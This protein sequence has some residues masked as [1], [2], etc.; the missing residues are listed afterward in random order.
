[1]SEPTDH[2][3][4]PG[5]VLIERVW[6][7]IDES[8][9]TNLE[10]DVL[11][12][13]DKRCKTQINAGDY[14]ATVSLQELYQEKF[15]PEYVP[16]ANPDSLLENAIPFGVVLD[17]AP[18]GDPEQGWE[19]IGRLVFERI[20]EY[21]EDANAIL[22][23]YDRQRIR[24]RVAEV[25]RYFALMRQ[26]INGDVPYEF[27]PSLV[28]MVKMDVLDRESPKWGDE[29]QPIKWYL[30]QTLE[31]IEDAEP[32]AEFATET[33]D[34][35]EWIVA[36]E[37]ALETLRSFTQSAERDQVAAYQGRAIRRIFT[38]AVTAG[39][40][41]SHAHVVTAST[42]GGKTEAFFFPLLAYAIAAHEAGIDGTRAI[43]GY[44][45]VDLCDNQFERF[46]DYIHQLNDLLGYE[47]PTF[48]EAPITIGLQHGSRDKATVECPY[49]GCDGELEAAKDDDSEVDYFTPDYFQCTD[50]ESHEI[51]YATARRDK[52]AD[53]FITT[54][55]S[56]HRRLMDEHGRQAF[57]SREYPPKFIGLDEVHV[58]SS[59]YGMHVA[60]VMRRL[61]Q[62]VRGTENT[63]EIVPF[64]ASATI[65]DADDFT[66]RIFGVDDATETT[67][68]E[69][70]LKE[71]GREYVIFVKSPDPRTVEIPTGDSVFKPKSEWGEKTETTTSNLS[72]MIQIAFGFYHTIYKD[73][74]G[75]IPKDK[76]L[77]FV[78][79]IDSVGRLAEYLHDAET[80]EKGLFELRSPDAFLPGQSE[81][82]PDCPKSTFRSGAEDHERAV[83]EPLPPNQHL[84]ECP[85]YE[86]GECWWTM[87]DDTLMPMDVG[88]HKSGRSQTP[89]GDDLDRW[90][91]L[92]S[93]SA[94][95]VGFDHP[96]IIGTF[97]YRA[98]MS[99]PGYVQ[100]RG[101][102]G[103]G[104]SDTPISVVVLGSSSEDSFY[105]HNEQQLSRPQ[106]KHLRI[107][108]DETNRFVR[109]E[110]MISA[111]FDY[112]NLRLDGNKADEI[113]KNLN[114]ET[115]RAEIRSHDD[116]IHDWL[117]D[118]FGVDDATTTAVI[119]RLSEYLDST[120]AQ[121]APIVET[122]P[123]WKM[124]R[125]NVHSKGIR[126]QKL[127]PIE[128][129]LE[130]YPPDE[131]QEKSELDKIADKYFS[132]EGDE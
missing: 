122:T 47:N 106:K 62:A 81:R 131:S 48:S 44:P 118:A 114:I 28:K 17:A 82:N 120:E 58:Y 72:S 20:I 96:S 3:K 59:Q 108:L 25:V 102:G 61:Q 65:A 85:V 74:T 46:I 39:D 38:Q 64:A 1:M 88:M 55:D 116:Q 54:P 15:H 40:E 107:P 90:D 68:K 51:R 5:I 66:Q 84:S 101:R 12:W 117:Q 125:A 103:R 6:E 124:L 52:S 89:T 71:E 49:S 8:L 99:I 77:G 45:R 113:Y 43:I 104:Q 50:D 100:R 60:N 121:V 63:Q 34:D 70:E 42:G 112:L 129:A 98:P 41:D 132:E 105:F 97:Q 76:I 86:A 9:V 4:R 69:A 123:F 67:P 23:V 128:H 35:D 27:S 7:N 14:D 79:S 57:W 32:A 110:H 24:S 26:R 21:L 92:I 87:Q 33:D 11:G 56:L 13:I 18:D 78:D 93:T 31:D 83:C 119:D 127:D 91:M 115:L 94:L 111:V 73:S 36:V 29:G 95:E 2:S 19:R 22:Y 30:Q 37:A 126:Q 75:D 53:I 16:S 10:D 130:N 109:T 80:G